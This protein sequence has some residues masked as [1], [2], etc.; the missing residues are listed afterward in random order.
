MIKIDP[1]SLSGVKELSKALKKATIKSGKDTAT[2][3]TNLI[4]R[5]L[6][7]GYKDIV[8]G[9]GGSWVPISPQREHVLKMANLL[10]HE[11]LVAETQQLVG[12]LNMKEVADNGFKISVTS[13]YAFTHE[14]GGGKS[15]VP[16]RPY[17]YPAIN[18]LK[19]EK[20]HEQII[21]DNITEAIRVSQR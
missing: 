7:S 15:N 21:K 2:Y 14:F 17:F 3:V 16:A 6:R 5:N 10:P 12:S 11:G 19:A 9:Y 20:I 13:K 4:E 8:P 1:I 18:Y